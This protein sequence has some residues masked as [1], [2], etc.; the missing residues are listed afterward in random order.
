MQRLSKDGFCWRRYNLEEMRGRSLDLQS[1][2]FTFTCCVADIDLGDYTFLLLPL[3][4]YSLCS[5]EDVLARIRGTSSP[6]NYLSQNQPSTG[7]ARL[8]ARSTKIIEY[9]E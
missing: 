2:L 6:K 1:E 3:T 7:S 9:F 5:L 8:K 4:L